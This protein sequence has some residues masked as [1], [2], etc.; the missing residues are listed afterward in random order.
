MKSKRAGVNG[1]GRRAAPGW[2]GPCL[3][4]LLMLPSAGGVTPSEMA[5]ASQ[6]G[7]SSRSAA[8]EPYPNE[9]WAVWYTDT[10]DRDAPPR[11]DVRG[12]GLVEGL[13]QLWARHLFETVRPDGQQGFSSFDLR[14]KQGRVEIGGDREGAKRLRGW[15]FGKK[16]SSYKGYAAEAEPALLRK[17]AVAH[18]RLIERQL[19][20]EQILAI[21]SAA[22]DRTDFENRLDDLIKK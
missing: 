3:A 2:L 17:T 7:V 11:V 13:A 1:R 10:F 22:K 21:A 20:A 14:W 8:G 6:V 12:R 5:A 19:R 16:E 15:V 9:E 18:A 4:A